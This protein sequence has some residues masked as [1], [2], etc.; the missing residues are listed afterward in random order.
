MRE[1]NALAN[2]MRTQ[3]GLQDGGRSQAKIGVVS[4]YN[5]ATHQVK[6][7]YEPEHIESGWMPVGTI[8]IGNGW[9]LAVGPAIGDQ[10]LVLFDGGEFDSGVI[11]ARLFSVT[12]QAIPVPT[13]EIWMVHKTTSSLKFLTNGDVNVTTAGNLNA[14]VAGNLTANI[15]GSGS[16]SATSHAFTGP[17]TM[18]STLKVA[19]DITDNSGTNSRTV[20]GMRQVYNTHTHSI[21][22]VQGGTST[23]TSNVPSQLE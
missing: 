3:S 4:S 21:P 6:V 18:S 19:G 20:A 9:G 1:F 8:G 14:T 11:V 10:M 17:V 16:Y 2:A 13:G 7:F 15:A 23:A 12:Q 5:P 22:N